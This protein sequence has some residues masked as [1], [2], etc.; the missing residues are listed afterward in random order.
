MR[1]LATEALATLYA[2]WRDPSHAVQAAEW[3]RKLRELPI[4]AVS[5]NAQ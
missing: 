5:T 4:Q 1:V 2:A 3:D